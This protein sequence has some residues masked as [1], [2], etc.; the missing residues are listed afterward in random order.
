MRLGRE[1]D[2]DKCSSKKG[3]SVTISLEINKKRIDNIQM[4]SRFFKT[5]YFESFSS[6]YILSILDSETNFL[7]SWG[8]RVL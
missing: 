2:L 6:L 4:K 1:V 7:P 3:V 8:F 5:F